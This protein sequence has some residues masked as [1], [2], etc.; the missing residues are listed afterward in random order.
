[1]LVVAYAT[2][3]GAWCWLQEEAM[4]KDKVA[5]FNIMQQEVSPQL[6]VCLRLK[7]ACVVH[8]PT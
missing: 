3:A 6:Y 1:L 5:L 8:R 4:A 2:A 7:R